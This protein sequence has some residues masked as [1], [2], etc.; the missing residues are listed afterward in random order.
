[1]TCMYLLLVMK[2]YN[3]WKHGVWFFLK[4]SIYPLW[5]FLNSKCLMDT[6]GHPIERLM[7]LK[8]KTLCPLLFCELHIVTHKKL[9]S[10]C[11][12]HLVRN[13]AN[14]Y[15]LKFSNRWVLLPKMYSVGT[16]CKW[17]FLMHKPCHQW[18]C[19]PIDS[20]EPQKKRGWQSASG[21][22]SSLLFAFFVCLIC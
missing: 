8:K 1:M 5:G 22:L 7:S 20:E 12:N 2:N 15:S 3:H 21:V 14:K 16:P 17:T 6:V 19:R 13:P 10:F 4:C 9:Y 11:W 18:L